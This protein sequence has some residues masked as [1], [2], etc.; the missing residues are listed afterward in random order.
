MMVNTVKRTI[1]FKPNAPSTIDYFKILEGNSYYAKD[2]GLLDQ[3]II[4]SAS[5]NLK[6]TLKRFK[7]N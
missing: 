2:Y 6:T 4:F 3:D 1:F 5:D 7:V